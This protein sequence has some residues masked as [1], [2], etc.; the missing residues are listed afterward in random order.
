MSSRY[1][2]ISGPQPWGCKCT[3]LPR[4][5]HSCCDLNSGPQ[6][7]TASTCPAAVSPGLSLRSLSVLSWSAPCFPNLTGLF[8]APDTCWHVSPHLCLLSVLL[9]HSTS[10]SIWGLQGPGQLESL[11][12]QLVPPPVCKNCDYSQTRLPPARAYFIRVAMKTM[13][14]GLGAHSPEYDL[15]LDRG[16]VYKAHSLQQLPQFFELHFLSVHR[17]MGIIM[18]TT[19]MWCRRKLRVHETPHDVPHG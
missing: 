4:L 9:P 7:G 18:V 1:L 3:H 13:R 5:S 6:A 2:P 16:L 19:A 14:H 10:S 12:N 8:P 15:Y 11:P 17:M